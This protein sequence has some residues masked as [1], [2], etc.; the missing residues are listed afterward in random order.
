[1]DGQLNDFDGYRRWMECLGQL[2]KNNCYLLVSSIYSTPLGLTLSLSLTYNLYRFPSLS[3]SLSIEYSLSGH[4]PSVNC[5]NK[6]RGPKMHAT[7]LHAYHNI[8]LTGPTCRWQ[9][10]PWLISSAIIAMHYCCKRIF[11]YFLQKLWKKGF[12]FLKEEN[13]L[14]RTQKGIMNRIYFLWGH[15]SKKKRI[16]RCFLLANWGK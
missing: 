10:G 16:S 3:P 2:S 14:S 7:K 1:M 4:W 15:C 5:N 9:D 6:R 12:P 13:F 8:Y 11:A